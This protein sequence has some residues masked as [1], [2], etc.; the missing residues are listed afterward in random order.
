MGRLINY[1]IIVN[2]LVIVFTA[3]GAGAQTPQSVPRM[4]DR[5]LDKASY[6]ELA[7]EWQKYIDEH[8]PTPEALVNL[9]MAHDYC[10]EVEAAIIAARQAVD[11]D[12][13]SPM[14]LAFL[15]KMLSKYKDD[16]EESVK[17]LERCRDIAP[18]YEF[19]LTN[20][21]TIYLRRGELSKSDEVFKTMFD[22]QLVA[23]PL[24]DFAYNMMVGLPAGAVLIT[25]GDND[26][27][28]PLALQAGKKFKTDVIILN[29]QL[30]NLDRYR[31]AFFKRYPSIHP[32]GDMKAAA[33]LTPAHT[34]IERMV[35]KPDVTVYFAPTVPMGQIG[36]SP[37]LSLEGI[38]RK[39]AGKGISTEASARLLLESYRLDSATD[40][41]Y[42]WDIS[43]NTSRLMSNYVSAMIKLVHE[44]Q[45]D[46]TTRTRLLAK[47][48]TIAEF[49]Q[50]ERLL[51]I[52]RSLE[53]K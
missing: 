29:R 11:L 43:Y 3:A 16:T 38:N 30:L 22:Q 15:G 31:D 5:C 17:L 49:H 50:D 53:S 26:T 44:G 20:L 27:F 32:G 9:G 37:E 12:P 28:P 46:K 47:A 51:H 34:L 13:D 41:G 45:P 24:Q 2:L 40:W 23:R 8:G 18:G 48:R 14:A 35:K 4:T 7:R 42:A 33:D 19:G 21:A 6:V 25:N 1:L 10:R 52:I 39:A 36:F